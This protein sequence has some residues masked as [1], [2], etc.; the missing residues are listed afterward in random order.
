MPRRAFA[1]LAVA[2]LAGCGGGE[3]E[4]SPRVA[5]AAPEVAPSAPTPAPTPRSTIPRAQR[6]DRQVVEG[7]LQALTDGD[8]VEAAKAFAPDAVVSNGTPRVRLQ[9]FALRKAFNA[10]FPCGA[11]LGSFAREKG[12]LLVTY[13]LIDRQG[14][15]CDSPG[16]E[17]RG[18]I[19]VRRG[20][21]SEWYRVPGDAPA[22]ESDTPGAPNLPA[23]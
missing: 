16:G 10:S 23:V 7:W 22:P 19:R 13:V 9:T 12:F 8:I 14:S 3:D 17:A 11:K 15:Q 21:I 20:R 18:I 4:P 6:S 5:T 1:L 2:V